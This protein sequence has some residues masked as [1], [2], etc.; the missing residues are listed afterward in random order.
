MSNLTAWSYQQH[1]LKNHALPVCESLEKSLFF[2]PTKSVLGGVVMIKSQNLRKIIMFTASHS[3]WRKNEVTEALILKRVKEVPR[4]ENF[5]EEVRTMKLFTVQ[6]RKI[7]RLNIKTLIMYSSSQSGGWIID[8]LEWPS[9]IF[10]D[11]DRILTWH[12]NRSQSEFTSILLT[13]K[14][15]TLKA[16]ERFSTSEWWLEKNEKNTYNLCRGQRVI[17]KEETPTL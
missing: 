3:W 5:Q 4:R 17:C 9:Q 16:I 10:I 13:N 6:D 2:L 1:L 11:E 8:C 14:I 12:T 15:A 7:G